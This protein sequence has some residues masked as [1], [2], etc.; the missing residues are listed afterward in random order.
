MINK[1]QKFQLSPEVLCQEIDGESVLLDMKSENYFGL[2]DVGSSM[3]EALKTGTDLDTLVKALLE[4]YDVEKQQLEADII[5]LL[6]QLLDAGL[7]LPTK[8]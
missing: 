3:L 6:Q 8:T 5:A 4:L 1:G 7:I 2:N